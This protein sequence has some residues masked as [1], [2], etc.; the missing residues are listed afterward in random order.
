M[1][2]VIQRQAA[3]GSKYQFSEQRAYDPLS[4]YPNHKTKVP[5]NWHKRQGGFKHC[6]GKRPVNFSKLCK[7]VNFELTDYSLRESR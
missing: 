5:Y 1:E 3:D 6:K 2:K 7:S 4:I